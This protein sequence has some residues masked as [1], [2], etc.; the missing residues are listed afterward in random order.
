MALR[1]RD[2][3]RKVSHCM[4]KERTR[5]AKEFMQS[6]M[7]GPKGWK[8]WKVVGR[9][10]TQTADTAYEK[11]E[12]IVNTNDKTVLDMSEMDYLSSAGLRVLLRLNKLAAK[13][14]KSFTVA[15]RWAWSAR[16][17]RT[18]AW[19]CCRS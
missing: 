14:G 17:R 8:V 5:M 15:G 7:E 6:E 16:C 3:I 13:S 11:G 1:E 10:D 2:I 18:A 19:T 9:I 4:K 12:A